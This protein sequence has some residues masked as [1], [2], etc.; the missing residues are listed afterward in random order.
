MT[1]FFPHFKIGGLDSMT[2]AIE[3]S[4]F[5]YFEFITFGPK[6]SLKKAVEKF[7]YFC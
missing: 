3:S 6:N 1:I 2:W 4:S 7:D 5:R